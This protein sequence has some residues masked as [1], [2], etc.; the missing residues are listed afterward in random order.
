M[1]FLK[2]LVA[3]IA[4]GSAVAV[5]AAAD[6]PGE[7]LEARS[8]ATVI[9]GQAP[10]ID[11]LV[12]GEEGCGLRARMDDHLRRCKLRTFYH[13]RAFTKQSAYLSCPPYC[14]PTYGYHPTCW[15]RMSED[16]V[17][18]PPPY[19]ATRPARQTAPL[20]PQPTGLLP[21]QIPPEPVAFEQEE[22]FLAPEVQSTEPPSLAP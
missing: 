4:C 14:S 7:E 18:C 2:S 3:A 15:R 10:P 8:T 21:T 12:S 1:A 13:W 19:D 5:A 17:A 22:E 16:C 6:N 20:Q 11:W 9:R